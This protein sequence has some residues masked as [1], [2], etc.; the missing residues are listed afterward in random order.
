MPGSSSS[1]K[2]RSRGSQNSCLG[3]STCASEVRKRGAAHNLIFR[4]QVPPRSQCTLGGGRAS[5]RL[6]GVLPR[7]RCALVAA[8]LSPAASHTAQLRGAGRRVDARVAPRAPAQVGDALSRTWSRADVADVL[9]R[10]GYAP[11]Y[12]QRTV[13]HRRCGPQAAVDARQ[14]DCAPIGV[15]DATTWGGR[16]A[17]RDF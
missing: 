7:A 9:R 15:A 10:A 11:P 3:A 4:A 13:V 1:S 6:V 14:R 12:F 8:V 2:T 16:R 17:C 5:R